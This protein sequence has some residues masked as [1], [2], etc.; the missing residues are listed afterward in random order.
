M[1]H[2]PS[3]S[4][5]TRS[6]AGHVREY[7]GFL[8]WFGRELQPWWKRFAG[9][10]VC[11]L[12]GALGH[13]AGFVV[14]FKYVAALQ[15][16]RQLA[17]GPVVLGHVTS[18]PVFAAATLLVLAL[19]LLSAVLEY[20]GRALAS[21]ISHDYR[22]SAEQALWVRLS[23]HNA[24]PDARTPPV[25]DALVLELMREVR[26]AESAA[27]LLALGLSNLLVLPV[28]LIAM[29]VI[30]W[31][32]TLI[33]LAVALASSAGFYRIS[34]Q[35]SQQRQTEQRLMQGVQDERRRLLERSGGAFAPLASDDPDLQRVYRSG[36]TGK[37]AGALHLQFLA[38]Q[39]GALI[40]Q[41]VVAVATAAIFLAGGL[42]AVGAGQ[43]WTRLLLYL[44]VLRLVGGKL[45]ASART[46]IAL[47]RHY[48]GLRRYARELNALDA[49]RGA[50]VSSPATM[51]L[52]LGDGQRE[53]LA[54]GEVVGVVGP[55]RP[56]KSLIA[57][58]MAAMPG[59]TRAASG[60]IVLVKPVPQGW[61]AGLD[62]VL[63]QP[64]SVLRDALM[65]RLQQLGL[66]ELAATLKA[67]PARL[68]Q[69]SNFTDA[70][71]VL[72][73][74]LNLCRA[75]D[76]GARHLVF[77]YDDLKRQAAPVRKAVIAMALQAGG[78]VFLRL[79]HA[80]QLAPS[81]VARFLQSDGERLLPAG[82]ADGGP[83]ATEVANREEDSLA[84][85]DALHQLEAFDD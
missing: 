46:L 41:I 60:G 9:A 52:V 1:K 5:P 28:G 64:Q 49:T 69:D 15:T 66:D 13:I 42:Q 76:H 12:G 56:K 36:A 19:M 38:T 16:D 72:T 35:I 30:D 54:S 40:G 65:A 63:G 43:G 83:V 33:V 79:T 68:R 45:A 57:Q 18:A 6:S 2:P 21:G 32:L 8:Q 51:S 53:V 58:L 74:L 61:L 48:A 10:A 7:L 31:Q 3:G 82:G 24:N 44:V 85:L 71:Q 84:Q 39:R 50:G 77:D 27:R 34:L 73:L 47:N 25:P 59:A 70:Q 17:L 37:T 78:I 11:S 55:P 14:V 22:L 26:A 81:G 75:T 62:R 4:G 29:L 23:A 67:L 80:N 20:Q